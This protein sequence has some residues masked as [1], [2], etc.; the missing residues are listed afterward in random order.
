MERPWYAHYDLEVPRSIDYPDITLP[1]L[2][3]HAATRYP[4]RVVTIFSGKKLRYRDVKRQIDSFAAGLRALGV[5]PGERVAIMLPNMPRFLVAFYGALRAGAVVVPTNP[6]Y[7]PHELEHQLGDA[8]VCVVVTLD[9]LFP[10]VQM[11]LPYTHV[12]AVICTGIGD[13]LPVQQQPIYAVKRRRQGVHLVKRAGIVHRFE[14]LLAHQERSDTPVINPDALAVLQY[15]GGTTGRSKGAMLSHRNLVAKAVQAYR[16]QAD[17]RQDD[18]GGI[19][20]VAPFFHVY[21]MTVGMNLGVVAGAALILAPR[22]VPKEV[23]ALAEKYRPAYLPGVPTMFVALSQLPGVSPRQFRSLRAC[24]S[25]A[26]PLPAD[27]QARFEA[28]SGA[29]VVE[30]YG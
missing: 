6:L 23:A 15:T 26:A 13:A 16:W 20:C 2:F 17:T 22:F 7:T 1:Q 24:M 25:G 10:T 3:E 30:G 19:L 4:D 5:Q 9:Q 27:V 18:V 21:G 14:E 29:R 12:R 11:A 8:G 28:L